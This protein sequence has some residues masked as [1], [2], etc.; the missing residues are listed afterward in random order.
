MSGNFA[1]SHATVDKGKGAYQSVPNVV[2][3]RLVRFRC[4]SD[5]VCKEEGLGKGKA[6]QTESRYGCH[7]KFARLSADPRRHEGPNLG[8]VRHCACQHWA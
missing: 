3:E 4:Q 5:S 1:Y 8:L 7:Q 6:C 2:I